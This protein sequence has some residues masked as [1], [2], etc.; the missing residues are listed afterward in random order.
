MPLQELVSTLQLAIGPVILISGIGL[1]L[2]S[3]TNRLGRVI[4][5]SRVLTKSLAEC[6]TTD[7]ESHIAQ[8]RILWRRA[9]LTRTAIALAT[10]SVLLVALMIITLFVGTVWQ[11][12]V[13]AL[14]VA[15]F[16]LCLVSLVASLGFFL[17]DINLTLRALRLELPEEARRDP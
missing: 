6:S 9:R 12:H 10:V 4:D 1:L 8:L 5:R 16:T 14:L 3:M 2:L 7:R 13:A 15:L 17:S 11:L